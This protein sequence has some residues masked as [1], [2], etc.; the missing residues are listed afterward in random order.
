MR[1][2]PIRHIS[3]L[4]LSMHHGTPENLQDC[5]ITCRRFQATDPRDEIFALL[6]ISSDAGT[7]APNPDYR[8]SVIVVFIAYARYL[9]L[10]GS[11]LVLHAASIPTSRH[12]TEFPS[13]VPDWSSSDT[14]EPFGYL[15]RAEYQAARTTAFHV[16]AGPSPNSITLEVHE[17][18]YV[19]E[20]FP[21]GPHGQPYDDF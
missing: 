5:L 8:E 20:L 4:R 10:K 2:A 21:P 7:A 19:K 3:R 6:G 11:P 18:D 16:Q 17:V 13:W 12:R 14:I 1:V 15:E 9:L